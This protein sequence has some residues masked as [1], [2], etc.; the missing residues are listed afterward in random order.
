MQQ[1]THYPER[2]PRLL[3]FIIFSRYLQFPPEKGPFLN[4]PLIVKI[5]IPK[6][7]NLCFEEFAFFAKICAQDIRLLDVGG[8]VVEPVIGKIPLEQ[9]VTWGFP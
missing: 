3:V 2:A 6:V 1:L 7:K 4:T 5:F 8:R 9:P